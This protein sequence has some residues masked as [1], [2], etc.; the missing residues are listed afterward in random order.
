M[1]SITGLIKNI[2]F[3]RRELAVIAL[4]VVL[5]IASKH[6]MKA[7]LVK[8]PIKLLPF[9]WLSYVENTGGAFGFMQGKTLWFIVFTL[10]LLIAMLVSKKEIVQYGKYAYAGYVLIIAGAIGNF[11]DRIFLG[12]VIDFLDFRIWPVFNFAD[13]YISVG[14]ILVGLSFLFVKPGKEGGG[15]GVDKK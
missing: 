11:A 15:K 13:S 12:Y 8:G 7:A 9:F 14:V 1:G 2:R 3:T 10:V 5:D 6:I 4:L